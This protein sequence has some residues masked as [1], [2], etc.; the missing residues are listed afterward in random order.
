MIPTKDGKTDYF[1]VW[2][3]CGIPFGIRRMFVWLVPFDHDL[4]ATWK[5]S[6]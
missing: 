5:Y 6:P 1:L 3:I 2:L 4:A